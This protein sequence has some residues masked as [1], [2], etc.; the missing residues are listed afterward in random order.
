[1]CLVSHSPVLC[2]CL[3]LTSNRGVT[4]CTNKMPR[5]IL[6]N[7][8]RETSQNFDFDYLKENTVEQVLDK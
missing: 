6:N 4:F 7:K 5:V 2:H 1:M 8:V 3:L